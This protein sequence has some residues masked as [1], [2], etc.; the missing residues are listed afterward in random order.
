MLNT[1]FNHLAKNP[2]LDLYPEALRDKIEEVNTWVYPNI[3]DGVY[4][5][6]FAR[7]QEA[8]NKNIDNLFDHLDKAEQILS[9]QRYITGDKLTEADIRLWTTLLRFDPVYFGTQLVSYHVRPIAHA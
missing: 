1:E 4:K 5:C 8:Y 2:S 6:G 7:S 3:N 9:K